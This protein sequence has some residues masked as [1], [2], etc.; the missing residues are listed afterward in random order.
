MSIN[1]ELYDAIVFGE[2]DAVIKI[3]QQAVNNGDDIVSLLNERLNA[4]PFTREWPFL[5]VN[6][7]IP[8]RDVSSEPLR[9]GVFGCTCGKTIEE[10]LDIAALLEQAKNWPDVVAVERLEFACFP[11]SIQD[12][13]NSIQSDNL[14]RIVVAACS[15]RTHDALFQRAIRQVGLNP[16]FVEKRLY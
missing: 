2:K 8:E 16:Y 10:V 6:N 5:A 9:I 12:I 4:H 14:N 1:D 7:L 13:Q 15:N 3:V 11:E